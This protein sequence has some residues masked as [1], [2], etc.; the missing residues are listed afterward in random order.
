ME[1]IGTN[2]MHLFID[3]ALKTTGNSE[4][5]LTSN[6]GLSIGARNDV[7]GNPDS[8]D[9]PT[10]GFLRD[11]AYHNNPP[12]TLA[13]VKEYASRRWNNGKMRP[14]GNDTGFIQKAKISSVSGTKLIHGTRVTRNDATNQ[15]PILYQKN[16]VVV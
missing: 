3:G 12:S 10:T 15:N 2:K 1:G 8:F 14:L 9:F 16:A 4:A 6:L 7:T 11:A 5:W 13:E